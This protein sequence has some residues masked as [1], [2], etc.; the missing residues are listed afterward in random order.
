[1]LKYTELKCSNRQNPDR[2]AAVDTAIHGAYRAVQS[3][4]LQVRSVL[5]SMKA[6]LLFHPQPLATCPW[7]ASSGH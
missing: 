3:V 2:S 6:E 5:Q 4:Q 1:M 7:R